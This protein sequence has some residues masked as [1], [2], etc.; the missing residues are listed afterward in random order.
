MAE[1]EGKNLPDFRN[2]GVAECTHYGG[3]LEKGLVVDG[4]VRCPWHQSCCSL[5]TS[6]ALRAPALDPLPQWEVEE[7]G[8][9]FHVTSRKQ[10]DPL[11]PTA[12]DQAARKHSPDGIVIIGMGAAGSAA[13]EMLRSWEDSEHILKRAENVADAVVIGASFIGLEVA[14][15]LWERGVGVSV[16]APEEVP[17][18][19]IF[20][21]EVGRMV[22][23]LH[24]E[25]GMKFRLGTGVTPR[26]GG[27]PQ[28]A[29]RARP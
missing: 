8:G 24:E 10:R 13:A 7:R 20:G 1:S 11:K 21:P 26:P 29:R 12:Y 23:E 15:A 25:H 4:T 16:A 19:R 28:H 27:R 5:R 2:T 6:E 9:R 22:K 18:A 17:L 14:A 3:P